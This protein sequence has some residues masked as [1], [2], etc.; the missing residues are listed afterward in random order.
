MNG[1]LSNLP[2]DFISVFT[3]LVNV[4]NRLKSWRRRFFGD[5]WWRRKKYIEWTGKL[6]VPY[7]K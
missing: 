1:T 2:I 4:A 3:M 5:E 7:Y 6:L